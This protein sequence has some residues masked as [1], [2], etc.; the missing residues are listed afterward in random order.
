MTE[1]S[2]QNCQSLEINTDSAGIQRVENK[3]RIT[4]K[5]EESTD[6]P[7]AVGD[8]GDDDKFDEKSVLQHRQSIRFR[9]TSLARSI[10]SFRVGALSIE[11]HFS[12]PKSTSAH[13]CNGKET[14]VFPHS[15][16]GAI[17]LERDNVNPSK[18]LT[19]KYYNDGTA[20]FY[21]IRAFYTLLA[22]LVAVLVF[23]FS[24]QVI[25]FLWIGLAIDSG[26]TSVQDVSL[27]KII[28]SLGSICSIPYFLLGTAEIMTN[29]SNFVLDAWEGH[30]FFATFF[31][32]DSLVISW[33]SMIV[34]ILIPLTWLSFCLLVGYTM[35]WEST[36]YVCFIAV[37]LYFVVFHFGLMYYET[38]G[39]LEMVHF[40]PITNEDKIF[41]SVKIFSIRNALQ[42]WYLNRKHKLS[43]LAHVRYL[44]VD[45]HPNAL[46]ETYADSMQQDNFSSRIG[47]YSRLTLFLCKVGWFERCFDHERIFTVNEATELSAVLNNATWSLEKVYCRDRSVSSLA[48]VGGEAALRPEQVKSSLSCFFMGYILKFL[49][50]IGFLLWFEINAIVIV[51]ICVLIIVSSMRDLR[52]VVNMGNTT[53]VRKDTS[54]DTEDES[55][56]S[57]QACLEYRI[58]APSLTCCRIVATVNLMFFFLFPV[59]CLFISDN[60]PVAGVF[61][62]FGIS[63]MIKENFDMSRLFKELGSL[64][65]LEKS[66]SDADDEWNKKHKYSLMGKKKSTFWLGVFSFFITLFG[67]VFVGAVFSSKTVGEEK[68]KTVPNFVYRGAG[69]L[70]YPTCSLAHIS[71]L[72]GGSNTSL[73]DFSFLATNT[74]RS[75]EARTDALRDWFVD[76]I[77]IE[78]NEIVD[79]FRDEYETMNRESAIE[80][81]LTGFP[82]QDV[83]IVSIRGTT[84]LI[85]TLVDIQ[86]WTGSSLT[87]LF[88]FSLPGGELLTPI[89]RQ[90]IRFIA[91]IEDGTLRQVS[92]YQ[93]TTAFML[94]L[95]EKNIYSNLILTGHSLGGG[96]AMITAVQSQIPSIAFSSP[97]AVLSRDSFGPISVTKSGLDKYTFNVIPDR[98]V[99]PLLDDSSRKIENLSCRQP[100]NKFFLC[101]FPIPTLCELLYTCGSFGRPIPC[102]CVTNY[103]YGN[104]DQLNVNGKTFSEVCSSL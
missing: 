73:V 58:S 18:P 11:D 45:D 65:G 95:K 16:Q 26:Y 70:K 9:R 83:G 23:L 99:V 34:Y 32:S 40:H 17:V 27:D 15:T 74:Y 36:L 49:V 89:F 61:V 103:E 96:I 60:I 102:A 31:N 104:P 100:S 82:D 86:L 76:E 29:A 90:M 6:K 54:L 4:W 92:F 69:N 68:L 3:Q 1:W 44:T 88:R 10:R 35:W 64:E 59:I 97:N 77:Y 66:C 55:T 19:V 50:V 14:L 28:L 57:Y 47:I 38:K 5:E 33:L 75:R 20:G 91:Y 56:C 80:Y 98:D 101:H 12:V 72:S 13:R 39:C 48:I 85:D 24:I 52:E 84:S 46:E 30:L 21:I 53:S 81:T 41:K 71:S 51:I 62:F 7:S 2:T 8:T 63:V 37:F 43:G 22:S 78:H 87:K 67:V 79:N 25:L 42:C 93:Q 94:Y